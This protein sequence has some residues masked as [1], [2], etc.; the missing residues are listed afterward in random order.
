MI[1]KKR[2]IKKAN[3]ETWPYIFYHGG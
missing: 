3:T 1:N 2:G